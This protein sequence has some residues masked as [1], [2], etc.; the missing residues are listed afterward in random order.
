[1]SKFYRIKITEIDGDKKKEIHKE[2]MKSIVLIGQCLDENRIVEAIINESIPGVSAL[3]NCTKK[4]KQAAAIMVLGNQ[5]IHVNIVEDALRY[6]FD[7]VIHYLQVVRSL[8]P[9]M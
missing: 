6:S 9:L 4:V 2:D 3:M 7:G 1:M 8:M 5:M